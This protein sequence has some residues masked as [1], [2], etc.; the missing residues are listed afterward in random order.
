MQY[1]YDDQTIMIIVVQHQHGG[2]SLRSV[3][4]PG[5]VV[6][7]NLTTD[8]D[9]IVGLHRFD[10]WE[11]QIFEQM[12]EFMIAWLIKGSQE[13]SCDSTSQIRAMS[14]GCFTFSRMVW[15]PGITLR[16]VQSTKH[17]IVISLLEDKK[18]WGRRI[19][20]VTFFASLEK[21]NI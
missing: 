8:A 7:D 3:W 15:D 17:Q 18:S 5:I 19:C 13:E 14:R 20:N 6:V 21:L 11:E 2:I 16:R 10:C 9:G 4:D 1:E 12:I